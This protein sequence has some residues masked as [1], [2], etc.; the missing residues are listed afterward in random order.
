MPGARAMFFNFFIGEKTD[1]TIFSS[2]K[3]LHR[4]FRLDSILISLSA[5]ISSSFESPARSE[6]ELGATEV[7]LVIPDSTV[8]LKR[9]SAPKISNAVADEKSFNQSDSSLRDH[10]HDVRCGQSQERAAYRRFQQHACALVRNRC[11]R[12]GV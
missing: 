9:K 4:S 10:H 3:N 2:G 1:N 11:T 12:C 8:V 7:T 6:I 5:I